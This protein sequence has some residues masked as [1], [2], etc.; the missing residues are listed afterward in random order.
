MEGTVTVQKKKSKKISG[1][2]IL[3]T[4]IFLFLATAPLY[5]SSFRTNLLGKYMCFALIV[6][7][8]DMI[9]GY[10]GILSLG[11][12]VY[13]GLGAYCMAMHLKLEASNGALPDFMGWS[14]ITE[15]PV[16]WAPFKSTAV[17]LILVVLIPVLLAA[18]IGYLT[19]INRIKG[20]YFSILS[21]ALSAALATLLIGMQEYFGG[22]NGLTNFTS[23][24][25]KSVNSPMT[26][27]VLFYVTFLFLLGAFIICS[28]LVNRRVGKVLIAI[29]DS[30]NRARFTGYNPAVY[31]VFV[32]C[33]SAALAGIAGA[34]YVPQV[35]IISPYDVNI[36]PSI[37]MVI[38]AAIGGKGTLVGPILGALLTNTCKSLISESFP[39]VW[40]YFLG[41]IFIVSILFLPN[42]LIS[43]KDVP[44]RIKARFGKIKDDAP[45][46]FQKD[47]NEDMMNNKGGQILN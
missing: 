13:F 10:T 26:K 32:Y 6:I 21:Q 24:F 47:E 42:G 25:G 46:E 27:L 22:S 4:L 39:E 12:G 14:G 11:H 8:I 18:V 35:G 43:L 16:F 31:K 20:V 1:K 19:F 7:G 15:L 36:S 2:T 38:W 5:M 40:S 34:L 23:I 29:R 41:V 28:I 33:L 3:A 37:E 17:S 9:W 45:A 30:E 44:K